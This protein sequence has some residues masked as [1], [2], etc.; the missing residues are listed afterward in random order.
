MKGNT[1]HSIRPFSVSR[2]VSVVGGDS[3]HLDISVFCGSA[4]RIKTLQV[5]NKTL[6]QC[7]PAP[8][9]REG[10]VIRELETRQRRQ[11]SPVEFLIL[12]IILLLFDEYKYFEK[13]HT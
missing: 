7:S 8:D 12:D 3:S 13:E 10:D 1:F 4:L 9:N 2:E 5:V 11:S 6:F